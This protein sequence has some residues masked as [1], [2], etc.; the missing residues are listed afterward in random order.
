MQWLSNE[1]Q[2]TIIN[3]QIKIRGCCGHLVLQFWAYP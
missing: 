3:H 1:P 2:P